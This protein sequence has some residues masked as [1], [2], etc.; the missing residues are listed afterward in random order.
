MRKRS[1]L[2]IVLLVVV[3]GT[4][5]SARADIGDA[6]ID[7]S[8]IPFAAGT[9]GNAGAATITL[10]PAAAGQWSCEMNVSGQF[11]T[12]NPLS[13]PTIAWAYQGDVKCTPP[14]TVLTEDLRLS[15]NGARYQSAVDTCEL[16][17]ACAGQS[18]T[19]CQAGCKGTWRVVA[20]FTIKVNN[21]FAALVVAP[22]C[23]EDTFIPVHLTCTLKSPGV[24][25]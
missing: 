20:T 3:G 8:G 22:G 12:V 14:V 4:F 21:V 10:F 9:V 13:A 2:A 17:T 16:N 18:S 25:V 6:D 7:V 23:T 11:A 5:G 24:I 19:L 1:V 15:L